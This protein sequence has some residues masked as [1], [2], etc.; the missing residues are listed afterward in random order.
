MLYAILIT[1]IAHKSMLVV[2]IAYISV[3]INIIAHIN[4]LYLQ[5]DL[6]SELIFVILVIVFTI[7]N[8]NTLPYLVNTIT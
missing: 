7:T 1:S 6:G 5:E 3:L 2:S 8:K 4:E